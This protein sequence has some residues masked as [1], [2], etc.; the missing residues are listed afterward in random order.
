MEFLQKGYPALAGETGLEM[1]QNKV[2]KIDAT[3]LEVRYIF[4]VVVV[5]VFLS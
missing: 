5:A 4:V 2:P 1:M 3:T